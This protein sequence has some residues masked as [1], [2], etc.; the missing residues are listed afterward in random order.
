MR[1]LF[2]YALVLTLACGGATSAGSGPDGGSDAASA[3]SGTD[4]AAS[5]DATS[6]GDGAN[7]DGAPVDGTAADGAGQ[8]AATDA[9][10]GDA[11]SFACPPDTCDSNTQFCLDSSLGPDA[12]YSGACMTIPTGCGHDC[13]CIQTMFQ[14]LTTCTN[15]NG[16]ITVKCG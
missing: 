5:D 12:G 11:G 7:G 6:G 9:S 1:S 2:P 16:R 8:D 15:D 3:E 13:A 14:C 4:A 10:G